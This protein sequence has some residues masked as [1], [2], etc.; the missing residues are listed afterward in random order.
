MLDDD[1]LDEY[2]AS[3]L[4]RQAEKQSAAYSSIGYRAF[5]K[6]S[7]K[8]GPVGKPNTRFLKN[9]VR[10][11]DGHNAALARKEEKESREK[12]H[13]LRKKDGERM[14]G[15]RE[16]FGSR[17]RTRDEDWRVRKERERSRSP[18]RR[19]DD[20][21]RDRESRRR[22]KRHYS[23]DGDQRDSHRE[24]SL[25]R[26]KSQRHEDEHENR[27]HRHSRHEHRSRRTSD[28][29][30]DRR[31]RRRRISERSR[32][33]SPERRHSRQRDEEERHSRRKYSYNDSRKSSHL[34]KSKRK[35]KKRRNSRE[36][37]SSD[38]R[39][40]S[41][42]ESSSEGRHYPT[43][44]T[45]TRDTK[46]QSLSPSPPASQIGPAP[47]AL[48]PE[49]L[50]HK[51]RGQLNGGTLDAKFSE[52]Y[53]P[54]AD[55]H[56][57]QSDSL[58][59]DDEDDWGLALRALRE[60]QSYVLSGAMTERLSE[61]QSQTTNIAGPTYS[62]GERE[63]DKGKVVLPDGSVGVQVWGVDKSGL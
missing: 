40:S 23:S 14:H 35:K 51:G 8:D 56:N 60:R 36:K 9:I 32:Q 20:D 33:Y 10:D 5:L 7:A 39:Q 12:L 57:Q 17:K 11:I 54:R 22:H 27:G 44:S 50:N 1:E 53:N 6:N 13:E 55:I 3:L 2:V 16:D 4:K 18:V 21:T 25:D 37:S 31:H 41:S 30:N 19:G 48:G 61:T 62:K 38:D 47:Q 24:S 26:R 52:S 15:Y 46:F 63:W 28:D 42:D 49:F 29:E 43:R 58:K 45:S 34:S 59:S